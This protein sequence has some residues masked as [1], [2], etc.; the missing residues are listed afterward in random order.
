MG[1]VDLGDVIVIADIDDITSASWRGTVQERPVMPGFISGPVI[2]E[3]LEGG[4]K[5]WLA[6]ADMEVAIDGTTVLHGL[7]RFK[8]SG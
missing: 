6:Q 2:A 8:G 5:R 7:E 1:P 4:R 3:L